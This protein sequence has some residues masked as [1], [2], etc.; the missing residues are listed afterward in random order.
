[1]SPPIDVP[2]IRAA[3]PE[4]MCPKRG[5]SL[6]SYQATEVRL[7]GRILTH[8]RQPQLVPL[9]RTMGVQLHMVQKQ[10]R[11]G[12]PAFEA[13]ARTAPRI[14][15]PHPYKDC[16]GRQLI[17]RHANIGQGLQKMVGVCVG[18]AAQVI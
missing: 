9:H 2:S 17:R 1:M 5:M 3:R 13:V 6:A 11:R 12:E 15:H 8:H 4:I 14:A 16:P 7:L 18:I 10:L